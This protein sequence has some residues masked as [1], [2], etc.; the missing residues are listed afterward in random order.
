MHGA[1]VAYVAF[2]RF[3]SAK[4]SGTRI[5]HMVG[6]LVDAGCEV[7]V[8]TLAGNSDF[9]SIPGVKLH[10]I[11]ILEN[12][13]LARAMRFRG[14]VARRLQAL[15]PDIIHFRGVFEGEAALAYAQRRGVP[16]V[17]EVNGLPSVE[18]RYHY[19]E[20]SSAP[21]FERRLR[22]LEK[23]V[24]CGSRH[25]MTQSRTTARFLEARGLPSATP[26][27]VIPNA[28]DP[29][30]HFRPI[31]EQPAESTLRVLYA[32]TLTPWQGVGELLMAI[33]RVLRERDVH[34][35]LAGPAPRRRQRRL[36]RAVRRLKVGEAV[37]F[38]GPLRRA[39]L[40]DLV[41]RQHVCAA[42]LRRDLRNRIQGAS[43]IKLYEYMC[44]ARA[45]LT[46]DLPCVREIVE[47][48]R[49]ALVVHS[50]R[51]GRLAEQLLRLGA[52]PDLRRRLGDA[53][54]ADVMAQATWPLRRRA[55]VDC[56]TE[57]LS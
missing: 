35:T 29:A 5:R 3:P 31:E 36:E 25:V 13:Y 14:Q 40:A 9:P 53:A 21:D 18:L 41:R 8:V 47:G 56:Y 42:P 27:V 2:E 23:R 12:N 22:D 1:R 19:T 43:P 26:A 7:H 10:P 49:N 46:T 20:L 55:L 11:R 57:W 50:P 51:P 52:D 45:V 15:A 32:G 39:D 30:I 48:E 28:A 4:G 37:T 44:A 6:A 17:F 33:R 38:T 34:L 16:T 24:L 54:H